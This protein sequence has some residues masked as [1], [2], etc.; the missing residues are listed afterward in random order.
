MSPVGGATYKIRIL[1]CKLYVRKVKLSPPVFLA[2]AEALEIGKA[3]FPIRRIVYKT[4]RPTIPRGNLNAS[5]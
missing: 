3:K 5:Q 2:H 1:G 4:F